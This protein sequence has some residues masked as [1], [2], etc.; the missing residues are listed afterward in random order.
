MKQV[1]KIL[2]LV[3]GIALLAIGVWS[4][5]TAL[6]GL[7]AAVGGLASN[8]DEG[9]VLLVAGIIVFVV[10]VLCLLFYLFAGIRGI[11][12]F[13]KGDEKNVR[14]AFIWAIIILVLNVF[15]LVYTKTFAAN[16]IAA[17][18]VDAAYV[19]GAFMVKLSK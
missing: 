10:S 2:L 13:T 17:L 12:T 14:K 16:T 1:G 8:K 9:V 3:A 11:K 15:S 19:T 4:L 7:I 5:I 6:L 18:V